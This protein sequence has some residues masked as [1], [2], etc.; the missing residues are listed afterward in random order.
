MTNLPIDQLAVAGGGAKN[1]RWMQMRANITGCRIRVLP[2]SETTLLGAAILAGLG[3][4]VYADLPAAGA[5]MMIEDGMIFEPDPAIHAIYRE[6][7]TSW[8]DIAEKVT[9]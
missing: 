2:H 1:V 6:K 3:C 4:E 5:A 9:D 8:L 7:L